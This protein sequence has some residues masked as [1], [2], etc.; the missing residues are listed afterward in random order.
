MNIKRQSMEIKTTREVFVRS[1]IFACEDK[2]TLQLLAYLIY[3][4]RLSEKYNYVEKKAT[5]L[6]ETLAL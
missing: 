5:S 3:D 4:G 6:K 2:N 1:F